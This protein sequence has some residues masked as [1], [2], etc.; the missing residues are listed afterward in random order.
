MSRK[1]LAGILGGL[2]FFVWS[3]LAHVV[4]PLGRTGFQEIPNEQVVISAMKTI[5]PNPGLYL[6]PGLGLPPDATGAQ[7]R[8]AMP[9]REQKVASG[10]SG[11]LI[12]FPAREVN[13]WRNLPIELGTNILQVLLAVFLLAQTSLTSFGARWR[14]VTVVGILAAI[15][16]NVSYWNFYGFPTS[17]TLAYAFTIAMGFVFAG[18]VA[19]AIVKPG[20]GM[21]MARAAGA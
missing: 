17:Y 8:A 2:A 19:A 1:L 12:Y 5:M 15:S 18:L 11:I 6:F 7:M 9:A 13:L 4:L 20:K 10:P 14:F 3:S 21:P 16:N